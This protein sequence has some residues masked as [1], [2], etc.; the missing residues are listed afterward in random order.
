MHKATVAHGWGCQDWK[1]GLLDSFLHP[2][3][4]LHTRLA[5]IAARTSLWSLQ[6]KN[7]TGLNSLFLFFPRTWRGHLTPAREAQSNTP[8]KSLLWQQLRPITTKNKQIIKKAKIS[9]VWCLQPVWGF[10]STLVIYHDH[11][12]MP[13]NI[14]IHHQ[15]KKKVQLQDY[16]GK[17]N[18]PLALIP[19]QFICYFAT[20]AN[21]FLLI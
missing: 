13:V 4:F 19:A 6:L 14:I 20:R 2:A 9:L 12:S 21:C 3:I 10:Y 11:L 7:P 8:L 17:I 5:Q 1:P 18:V 16:L 15:K